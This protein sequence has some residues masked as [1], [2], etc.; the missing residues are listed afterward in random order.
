[1]FTH[2]YSYQTVFQNNL[3]TY[4]EISRQYQSILD[5]KEKGITNVTISIHSQPKT[6]YHAYN[7][8]NN[9]AEDPNTG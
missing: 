1:M 7:G 6:L 5:Q 4:H 9:L 3:K 8:T 2:T